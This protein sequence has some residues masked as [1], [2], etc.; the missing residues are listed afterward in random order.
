M[1]VLLSDDFTGSD[2]DPILGRTMNPGPGTWSTVTFNGT[3]TITIQSNTATCVPV[4]VNEMIAFADAEAADGVAEVTAQSSDT[5][6][7]GLLMRVIDFDNKLNWELQISLGQFA[8]NQT[9][10]GSFS[11]VAAYNGVVPA[12]DT[13]YVLRAEMAGETFDLFLDSVEVISDA[14]STVNQAVTNHGLYKGGSVTTALATWDLFSF[15]GT[16]PPSAVVPIIVNS[17][18]QQRNM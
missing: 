7:C 9:V 12:A 11:E 6:D 2:G 10:G 16:A 15:N 13:P 18:K 4:T 14:V 8:F 5:G 3:G 1:A 17:L